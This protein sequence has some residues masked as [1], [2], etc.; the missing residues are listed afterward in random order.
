MGFDPYSVNPRTFPIGL[1][2]RG[3]EER[4]LALGGSLEVKSGLS[5]GTEVRAC[6]PTGGQTGNGHH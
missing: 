1:G 6:F 2:L 3:M 4:A 5:E